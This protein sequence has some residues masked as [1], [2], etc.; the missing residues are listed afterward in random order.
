MKITNAVIIALVL[1]LIVFSPVLAQIISK[2]VM[3]GSI[4][5]TYDDD[6][7]VYTNDTDFIELDYLDFPDVSNG[8]SSYLTASIFN[9]TNSTIEVDYEVSENISMYGEIILHPQTP[10][11]LDSLTHSSGW[12]EFRTIP[13]L[14]VEDLGFSVNITAVSLN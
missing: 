6:I 5:I 10:F 8:G 7:Q 3:Q 12:L 2:W 4:T 14:V 13:G 11:I 9:T 1:L